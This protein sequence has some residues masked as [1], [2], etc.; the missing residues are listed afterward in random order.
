[1]ANNASK[2]SIH[3]HERNSI[4]R[5]RSAEIAILLMGLENTMADIAM[6]VRSSDQHAPNTAPFDNL[7][8]LLETAISQWNQRLEKKLAAIGMKYEQWRLLYVIARQGPM[9]IRELSN[10]ILVPHSTIGRWLSQMEDDGYVK[11][12]VLPRDQR[13]VEVSITPK[14][15]SFFM[16]ALPIAEREYKSASKQFTHEEL[17]TLIELMQKLRSN[18]F[19][20]DGAGR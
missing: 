17:N 2:A 12:R 1:M 20:K 3:S 14:G 15:R 10:L 6:A 11:R 7:P 19:Q 16:R 4:A 18:L 5:T 13:A 9:N 8:H